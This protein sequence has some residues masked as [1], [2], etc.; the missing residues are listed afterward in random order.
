MTKQCCQNNAENY[1]SEDNS[2]SYIDLNNECITFDT[3]LLC[4]PVNEILINYCVTGVS[5]LNEN[6]YL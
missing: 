1:S 6:R 2:Y 3:K 4:A 5:Y